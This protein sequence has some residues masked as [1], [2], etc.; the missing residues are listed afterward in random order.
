MERL[1]LETDIC[2]LDKKIAE[3]KLFLKQKELALGYSDANVAEARDRWE[4]NYKNYKHMK[5]QADVVDIKEFKGVSDLVKK[6][7]AEYD[8]NVIRNNELRAGVA[9][10]TKNV[11]VAT[12]KRDR[13]RAQLD[14]FGE[15]VQ[16]KLRT[17]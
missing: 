16:F 14:A 8:D 10:H 17:A 5:T 4:S 2:D 1:Q 12:D 3:E 6:S 11:Q 9:H 7:K 13:L 15:V